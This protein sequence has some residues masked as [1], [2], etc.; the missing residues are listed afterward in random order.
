MTT[1]QP[2]VLQIPETL[3]QALDP[4]WLSWALAP[5][6]GGAKV[7]SVEVTYIDN[8]VA[9]NVRIAVG[10][11]NDP[12]RVRQYCVK[13]MLDMEEAAKSPVEFIEASFYKHIAPKISMR[14]PACPVAIIDEQTH[15]AILI[16]DDLIAAG[17]HFN[18]AHKLFTLDEVKASLDQLAR[19][20]AASHL[21]E[22]NP[23][24]TPSVEFM[25]NTTYFPEEWLHAQMNDGRA[26]ELPLNLLTGANMR[27]AIDALLEKSAN[28][29][30]TLLHGDA[31]IANTF[32]SAEGPGFADWQLLKRG[33]WALDVAYHINTVLPSE[34]AAREE[35]ALVDHYLQCVRKHGGN[36]VEGE[37]AWDDYSCAVAYGFFLWVITVHVEK[38]VIHQN[39]RSLGAAVV[40]NET[41]KRLGVVG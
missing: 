19:L 18:T 10:F 39:Y 35:K 26:G 38:K 40:R 29:P 6:T 25:L 3:E 23:W 22:T 4:A 24:I 2:P 11:D 16:M 30:Q 31:H 5:T 33:L 41:F 34:V 12:A 15:N 9:S 20:H 13:G 27:K 17:G 28:G 8:R 36:P 7:T 32:M 21:L 1:A 37:K 14:V